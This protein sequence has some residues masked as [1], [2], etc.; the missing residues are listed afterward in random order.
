MDLKA[1]LLVA[2]AY[3]VSGAAVVAACFVGFRLFRPD[4]TNSFDPAQS[5]I[6]QNQEQEDVRPAAA[7]GGVTAD[8]IF[9]QRSQIKQL[10]LLLAQKTDLLDKKTV[11]LNQKTKEQA[12]LET[13]LDE[14]IGMLE[15]LAMD[16]VAEEQTEEKSRENNAALQTELANLRKELQKHKT[17]DDRQKQE[18]ETLRFELSST[19]REIRA[20]EQMTTLEIN[21]LLAEKAALER[22]ATTALVRVGEAAVPILV[23]ALADRRTPIRMWA[24]R[25]LGEMGPVAVDAVPALLDISASS[26]PEV[27]A[28]I[29]EALD[30]ISS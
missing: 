26:P 25:T 11:L 20:V 16:V 2:A 14:A 13:Q 21:A 18:L 1:R 7:T 24:A 6:S 27:Q 12:A 3:F 29:R 22:A 28:V 8:Q 23:N 5:T 17:L 15:M 4:G 30:A 19:D 9:A 10:R